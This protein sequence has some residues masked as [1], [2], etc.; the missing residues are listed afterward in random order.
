MSC[1][2]VGV[3]SGCTKQCVNRTPAAASPSKV[4]VRYDVPPFA[5]I[6]SYPKSSA[7]ISTIFGRPAAAAEEANTRPKTTTINKRVQRDIRLP[8]NGLTTIKERI[9]PASYSILS[10]PTFRLFLSLRLRGED[11]AFSPRHHRSIPR[12]VRQKDPP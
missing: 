1:I 2:R 11:N 8:C 5:P 4:G 9:N 3:H 6:V 12:R 10:L 7:M